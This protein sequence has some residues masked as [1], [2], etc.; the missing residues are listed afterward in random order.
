MY[1]CD[2]MHARTVRP[3]KLRKEYSIGYTVA[4]IR[5]SIR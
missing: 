5:L 4:Y 1:E 3:H 2:M